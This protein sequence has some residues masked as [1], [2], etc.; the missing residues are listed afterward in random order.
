[1]LLYLGPA[2]LSGCCAG[3]VF[4]RRRDQVFP[5]AAVGAT[6]LVALHALVALVFWGVFY[7]LVYAIEIWGPRAI[8]NPNPILPLSLLGLVILL[9]WRLR[10]AGYD[11]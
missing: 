4:A 11:R 6:V 10:R 3:G 5:L 9:L 8:A 2:L 7:L 1:M